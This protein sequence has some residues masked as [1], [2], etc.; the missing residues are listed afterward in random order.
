VR[1]LALMAPDGLPEVRPGDDLG[2]LIAASLDHEGHVLQAGD[3]VVVAQKIVSKS[4]GRLRKL[5]QYQATARAVE[6][7]AICGK[8]PRHV[9]AVLQESRA[10]L[11]CR[12]GVLVVEDVRGF[13]MANAGIDAS[14]VAGDD[15]TILLLPLDPDVSA[16]QLRARLQQDSGVPLGVVINDSWGRAWR[17]GT[18]GTAL[19]VAGLPG[20]LDLRGTPDRM[21]RR[22]ATTE[23]GLA[24]EVAAAASVLM[25]QA[26][27]GRPV[28]VVRGVPYERRD[29]S[30]R[31]LIRSPAQDLFR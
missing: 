22:L 13:V 20:L 15:E 7:A 3:V 5:S 16:Q 28:V 8:D 10:V 30:A 18:V 31:E 25:G 11:R 2:R 9:E 12:P 24:D 26:G 21:G 14:N 19:G 27:E 29:G 1:S 17:R 4:E 6:L 23:I